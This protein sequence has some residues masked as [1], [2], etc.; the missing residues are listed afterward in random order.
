MKIRSCPVW[1][2]AALLLWC[3]AG[4]AM[5]SVVVNGTRVIVD[6]AAGEATVQLRN[7]GQQPVLVQAWIDD[8]DAA[9]D[10]QHAKSPFVLTPPVA[11]IDAQKGQALRIIRAADIVQAGHESLYWLNVVEVPPKPAARQAGSDN[12]LMFSFRTRIKVFYRPAGLP[13]HADRAHEQ[14]CFRYEPAS[15]SLVVSNPTPYHVSFRRL[16][17]LGSGGRV[18]GELPAR[19]DN[20]LAP[21]STGR[22][23]LPVAGPLPAHPMVA[24]TVINDH[25]GDVVGQRNSVAACQPASNGR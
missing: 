1:V 22:F 16:A 11:R 14:L 4:A 12:V 13:G 5:A 18:A 24:Y 23:V 15:R 7:T 9:A 20:M 2:A 3:A 8:G 21:A 25:G 10:P 17:L 19:P 6:G